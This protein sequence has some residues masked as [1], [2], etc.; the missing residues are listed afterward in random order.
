[1]L[2]GFIIGLSLTILIVLLIIFIL[3]TKEINRLTLELKKLNRE[4]KIEKLRLSL[5]NKN[6]EN[7]IVEINTLIDD[8]RK[9]EN[10]YK[11]KDMELREAIANMSHD[12]RT[13]LTSIIN[14]VDLLSKDN[15][16]DE[17]RKKYIGVLKEKSQRLKVLIE[18][19]FEASKAASG[20][21]ELDIVELDPIALLRQT[22]GEL[23]DKIES[24]NLQ[25]IKNIPEEKLLILADGKKTFRVFQNL[26]SNII[27]YSM[28]GSRVYIDVE[29]DEDYVKIIFKNISE[30]PLNVE[31]EEL[32]ERFKRGD[33]SRTTEGSGLGLSIAKSL[34]ELQD[35]EFNI[36]IDGDLF[37]A[38]VKLKN[39]RDSI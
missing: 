16:S 23:E 28:K 4:G 3:K 25:V 33:V 6:I 30:S 21:I 34:V 10:I 9:M 32:M 14:Y 20:A 18:D 36:E 11:E 1:M 31:A 39:I 35:G 8:K 38:I 22:I 37:K 26:L 29:Q 24:S 5:P 19:L 2:E 12:L 27:K 13:P 15:I 7:L 17:E